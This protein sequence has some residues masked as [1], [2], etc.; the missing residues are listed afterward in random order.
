MTQPVATIG[1]Q[2][3]TLPE[4]IAKLK[5]AKVD[6]LVDVRAVAASRRPGFSK[7]ILKTS[8]QAEG[9]G[10]LHLRA[11][12]TPKE[13][14]IASRAGRKDE[15]RRIF[16]DQMRTPEAQ[17]AFAQL[18]ALVETRR[19]ALLCYEDQPEDCHR[20][21]LSDRLAAEMGAEIIDL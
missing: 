9:V 19:A 13:G 12:G 15:M 18:K 2:N 14:R 17:D 7:T 4:V 3:A 1:Y 20:R 5:A 10:Y 6:L 11:L 8:L 16:E 21:V